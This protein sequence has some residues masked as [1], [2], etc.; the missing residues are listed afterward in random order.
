[1]SMPREDRPPGT[2][3]GTVGKR[4]TDEHQPIRRLGAL[5]EVPDRGVHMVPVR[6]EL[7]VGRICP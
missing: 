1:M 6:D 2:R 7:H 5:D 4:V 3:A